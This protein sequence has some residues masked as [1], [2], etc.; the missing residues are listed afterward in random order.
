MTET[1]KFL[2]PV[3][4]KWQ[5][6]LQKVSK[7]LWNTLKTVL[8]NPWAAIAV[9]AAMVTAAAIMTAL[10]NKS[11]ESDVPALATGGLAYG[12]TIALVGDNANASVDPEVIAPL[13][14]LQAMLPAAGA[15]QNIKI[16]LDGKLTA[17]GRDLEFILKN[18]NFKNTVM[19]R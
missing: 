3:F 8:A 11:A 12:K 6:P 4:R 19:G 10:I 18:E 13:S 7:C 15:S 14:K 9:G 17:K 5:K 2:I 1:I 16:S